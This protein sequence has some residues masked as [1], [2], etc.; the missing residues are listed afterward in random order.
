MRAI[1][2][3]GFGGTDRLELVD[4]PAPE[5]GPDDVL[6][7]VRAAGVGSWDAKAR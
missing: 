3:E 2:I 5:P 4:L 7:R 1:A 6:V